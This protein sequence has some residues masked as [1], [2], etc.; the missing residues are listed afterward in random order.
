MM[1]RSAHLGGHF[2]A[3]II[4]IST[5][6]MTEQHFTEL[7]YM[8]QPTEPSKLMQSCLRLI[9]TKFRPEMMIQACHMPLSEVS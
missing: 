9:C 4:S 6:T 1:H 7:V 8:I 2:L 5:V 3:N